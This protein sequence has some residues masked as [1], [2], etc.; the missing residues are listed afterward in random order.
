MARPTFYWYDFETF[1]LNRRSSRPAQFAGLRT[2]MDFNSVGRGEVLYNRLSRDVL[3][4]PSSCLIT[5]ITPQ[6][7]EAKGLCEAEFS[8]EVWKRLNEPDTVSIG[9]NTLGF[10]DE[11]CR[12][13]FWRNFLDPY[14]HQWK[15]GC[16]RWDLYPIVLAVWALRGD[17]DWIRWPYWSEL[18]PVRHPGVQDREG[19]SFKLELL[20]EFNNLEH[21]KA[22]DALSDV[23]ATVALA[24]LIATHEPRLWK[25]AFEHRDKASVVREITSG[26]FVW[27]SPRLT[28]LR[29]FTAVVQPIVFHEK[30]NQ[31]FVWDLRED[32]SILL[33]L[34]AE[35]IRERLGS[36]R[37]LEEKKLERLPIFRLKTNESPFVCSSLGII[38]G[39][40]WE[41][42]GLDR[43]VIEENAAKLLEIAP[44]VAGTVEEGCAFMSDDEPVEAEEALYEG[45]FPSNNDLALRDRVRSLGGE[46]LASQIQA[47][48]L[49]FEDRRFAEML[50]RYLARNWPELLTAEQAVAWEARLRFVLSGGTGARSL[51]EF[52]DELDHRIEELYEKGS[53][54]DEDFEVLDQLSDWATALS[55]VFE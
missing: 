4:E 10:D 25:W 23:E 13:L 31:A 16:S 24:K 40:R 34:S 55:A 45:G 2:D 46:E 7:C 8:Q 54:S 11:V 6:E 52:Q 21:A 26:P 37:S 9:Y 41:A 17:T 14:S 49:V 42:L 33:S 5:H 22:H 51:S 53:V 3:P 48:H 35:E 19:V 50:E 38:R 44:R 36:R 1:G 27:I 43:R 30:T 12:F 15:S 20:T 28:S 47:G 32:P 29:K 39:S 18:D